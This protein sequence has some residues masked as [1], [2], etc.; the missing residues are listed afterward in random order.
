MPIQSATSVT[1]VL[2]MSGHT[3]RQDSSSGNPALLIESGSYGCPVL[4]RFRACPAY[5]L[6]SCPLPFSHPGRLITQEP[7]S[8]S[9]CLQQEYHN[10]PHG[11]HRACDFHRTRLSVLAPVTCFQPR[12]DTL[13][14]AAQPV[15]WG[16]PHCRRTR[17]HYSRR[18]PI[19]RSTSVGSFPGGPSPCPIHYR[20]AFGMK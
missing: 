9:S 10:A 19:S 6:C 20:R 17:T 18:F 8:S 1:S 5:S 12:S 16:P 3:P 11:E 14:S 4:Q 15:A 2:P 13:M 7:L